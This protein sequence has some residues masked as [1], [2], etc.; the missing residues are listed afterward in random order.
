MH[1]ALDLVLRRPVSTI[2]LCSK[3]FGAE[4]REDLTSERTTSRHNRLGL[5]VRLERG[6]TAVAFTECLREQVC[7][8][9]A[10]VGS[11]HLRL[12]AEHG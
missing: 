9:V 8:A 1:L 3:L 11:E 10:T 5:L 7:G 6:G 2:Q 12:D 4:C